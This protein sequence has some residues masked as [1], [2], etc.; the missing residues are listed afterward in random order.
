MYIYMYIYIQEIS[1]NGMH[2]V[3]TASEAV[4]K[5]QV[6]LD[7]AAG[8][9]PSA[10]RKMQVLKFTGFTST[11]VQNTDAAKKQIAY[12]KRKKKKQAA[13]LSKLDLQLEL[14]EKEA[15]LEVTG[16]FSTSSQIF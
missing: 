6:L 11:K 2:E 16:Y 4:L 12:L 3:E 15:T 8:E 14:L 5:L 10:I 1:L 9:T 7:K 13:E